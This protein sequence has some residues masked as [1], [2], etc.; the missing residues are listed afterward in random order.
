M[1]VIGNNI[2]NV[3]TV[4]FKGSRVT[5]QDVFSQTMSSGSASTTPQQVGLGVG[6]ASTDLNTGA[7]SFQLTGRELDLAIEGNGMFILKGGD[8]QRIYTRVG[9]FDWDSEGF[10]VNPGTGSRVQGWMADSSGEVASTSAVDLSDIKLIK[11]DVALPQPS[12]N[13]T[14]GGNLDAGTADAG[15]Y[16]TTFTAYDSLGNPQSIVVTFTKT[17]ANAWSWEA[18]GPVDANVSGTGNLSFNTDGTVSTVP[19]TGTINM[20]PPGAESNQ[21]IELDFTK[22]TQAYAGSAGSSV[23]VR[24][25]DGYPMG[26]LESVTVDASGQITGVFSNGSRRVMAQ[27]GMASF[28]NPA[29]LQKIGNSAFA[30]SSSSGAPLMGTP[31]TGGRGRLVPGNLEMSNVDL[32]AEFTNMIV[33][34]RGFQANTRVITASDEMLQDVV[35]LR[36]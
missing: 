33:T 8:G 14:M 10:L 34:Q 32:S 31:N 35:N 30:E 21:A 6:I 1:D 17:S 9:N 4:G 36:R 22:V 3:N 5:F 28:T 25:V 16:Q 12:A 2:A 13:V 23:L 29:G 27:V 7:G 18:T 19:P 11:G 26:V 20:S 24:K 15:T